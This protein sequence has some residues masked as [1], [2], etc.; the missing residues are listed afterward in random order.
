[1]DAVHAQVGALA[2]TDTLCDWAVES[3]V[4]EAAE[5]VKVHVCAAAGDAANPRKM[6]QQERDDRIDTIEKSATRAETPKKFFTRYHVAMVVECVRTNENLIRAVYPELREMAA[7]LL[8]HE[9]DDH[10]LQRTALVHEAFLRLFGKLPDETLSTQSFLAIAAHQMR[11]VLIDYGR[12]RRSQKRGGDF[13]RVPLFEAD[14]AVDHD[15]DAVLALDAALTRLGDID[16][17]T[18]AIAELKFFCGYTND[19]TAK[20]LGVSDGTV[21]A[22]WQFARSWLFGALTDKGS[23]SRV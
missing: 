7:R 9:R 13:A 15:Q 17:R 18:V 2:V 5:R 22:D 3:R 6:I 21:E 8:R 4:N 16:A 1:M 20:I 10:T 19:E 11:E 14:H 23:H 12:K